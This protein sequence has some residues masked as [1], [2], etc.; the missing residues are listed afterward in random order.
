M[1]V[2]KAVIPVAGLGTRFLPATKATPKEMI[3]IIDKPTIQYIIE[4]VV[5]SGIQDVVLITGRGKDSIIDH[6]DVS[7]ELEYYL[8]KRGKKELLKL[9]QDISNMIRITAVRQ[10][11]PLGLG[12]AVL[13]ARE[14][15]GDE[16]FALLLGDDMT[17][18][19]P[20][21]TRQM[22]DLFEKYQSGVI[23]L[24]RVP[25]DQTHLYGIIEGEEVEERLFKIRGVVEKPKPGTSPTNLAIIG[26]YILPPRIF[27]ILEEVKPDQLRGDEIQLT[28]ALLELANQNA[29]Y[30]YE[31][32]GDRYDIGDKF[33]FVR[34]TIVFALKDPQMGDKLREFLKEIL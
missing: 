3:P 17:D 31:F 4:E 6:F 28:D 9:V 15:V 2:R 24:Q 7:G 13:C 20:P 29:L 34:A 10:K 25:D 30:G 8:E 23:A 12:H 21:L 5:S 32:A 11:K 14:A 33:G 27:D 22:I 26:R 19:D 18:A 16:P 1:L